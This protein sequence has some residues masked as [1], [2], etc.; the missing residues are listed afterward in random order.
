MRYLREALHWHF[1]IRLGNSC[2]INRPGKGWQQLNQYHWALGEVVSKRNCSTKNRMGFNWNA[3]KFA[4]SLLSRLCLVM[5]VATL[6]LTVQ[7]QQVVATGKQRWS[8][9]SLAT[10]E[11]LFEN[12]LELAQG[13][14]ASRM[15][16]ILDN[17]LVGRRADP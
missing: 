13:H 9:C 8:G 14:L 2:W 3:P 5:A 1:R 6:L 4:L 7:G 17:F 12:R 16:F 15:V 10:G 11:Q